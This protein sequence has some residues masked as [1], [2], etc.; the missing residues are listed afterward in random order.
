MSIMA[1]IGEIIKNQGQNW[2]KLVKILKI[3]R[4]ILAKI[5]ETIKN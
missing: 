2:S 4:S 3:I 5:D 1:K